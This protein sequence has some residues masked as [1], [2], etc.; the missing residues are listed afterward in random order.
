M[1]NL[2]STLIIVGVAIIGITALVSCEKEEIVENQQNSYQDVINLKS[3][4][5]AIAEMN[6]YMDSLYDVTFDDSNQNEIEIIVDKR[7]V[8][9]MSP[10]GNGYIL[11]GDEMLNE[12]AVLVEITSSGACIMDFYSSDFSKE[13]SEVEVITAM[14]GD[15]S[16]DD[17]WEDCFVREWQDFA[18]DFVTVVTQYTNPHMVAIAIGIHCARYDY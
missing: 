18:D 17:D 13:L 12:I 7:D 9:F 11:S 3:G 15:H 1:R 2:K 16:Q 5:G 6:D 4:G 14:G 10:K 8:Y